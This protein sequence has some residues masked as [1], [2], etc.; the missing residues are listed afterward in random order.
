MLKTILTAR[1]LAITRF[2]KHGVIT[3][4]KRFQSS[5]SNMS[6]ND[7]YLAKRQQDLTEYENAGGKIYHTPWKPSISISDF[8][9][10]YSNTLELN[11]RKTDCSYTLSGRVTSCRTSGSNLVFYTIVD[12]TRAFA[13]QIMSIKKEFSDLQ[14]FKQITK[15]IK[16]GDIIGVTGI[17]TKTS[18]GELSIIPTSIQLLSPC[19]HQLPL[20]LT[21]PEIR[22]RNRSLDMLVNQ[23][24]VKV[25][26]IRSKVMNAVRTFFNERNYCEVETPV[27][28]VLSGGAN[29]RP[30]K[31]KLNAMSLDLELRIA[32][33]LYLKQ[34]VIGGMERVYELGKVFR[35][36]GVDA[37]H[38]PEFTSCESYEAYANYEDMMN[39]T[40]DFMRFVCKQCSPDGSMQI[41]GIDF[42]PEFKRI[43]YV[44]GIE[45]VVKR[46]LPKPNDKE[47][48]EVLFNL[49][50]EYNIRVDESASHTFTFAYLI[51][52][53]LGALVEPNCI[54][55]TF[56]VDYPVEL[57][58]LARQ[59]ESD[60]FITERF[61]LFVN[62]KEL[63]NAYTEL[64]DP[65]EQRRRFA[66]QQ[67]QKNK[68]DIEAQSSD[69]GF[70]KALELGLPPTGGWG[71]GIDRLV[72]MISGQQNI[73]DVL[74]FPMMK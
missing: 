55:P 40:Q 53:L 19:M 12:G 45:D 1:T 56:I 63:C 22:F 57:S 67:E 31:T 25:F 33:E 41:N 14:E 9:Q 28:N 68:G 69:E 34:L 62:G 74:L 30:F 20:E 17:P 46:T 58:P 43:S 66:Q 5:A 65:R 6:S 21:E 48:V 29:A 13:V 39:M 38:N 11:E 27:L 64:N 50:K 59:K 24:I 35:N 3:A 4:P 54:Q 60:P 8:I 42:E 16:K 7:A 10:K 71:C 18:T 23:D 49:C 26:Q 61:E 36:E 51:D 47:C 44:K 73:R 37:T 72:M 52:K 15:L 32:P 70:C 2:P